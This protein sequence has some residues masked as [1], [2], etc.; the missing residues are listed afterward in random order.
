[1][2]MSSSYHMKHNKNNLTNNH[3]N[4]DR[5]NKLTDKLNVCQIY[6]NSYLE[7]F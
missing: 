1:M 7:Y 3:N 6:Y 2:A 4:M 5:L